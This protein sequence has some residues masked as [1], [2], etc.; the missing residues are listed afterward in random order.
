MDLPYSL[1]KDG[2]FFFLLPDQ[3]VDAH[4]PVLISYKVHSRLFLATLVL[5]QLFRKLI[6]FS[7]FVLFLLHHH[8]VSSPAFILQSSYIPLFFFFFVKKKFNYVVHNWSPYY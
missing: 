3:S 6:R 5:P 4:P 1:Q 8:R 7:I 2:N